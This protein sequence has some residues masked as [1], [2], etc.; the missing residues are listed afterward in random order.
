MVQLVRQKLSMFVPPCL[1]A[2]PLGALTDCDVFA[3]G[4]SPLEE[5]DV[6]YGCR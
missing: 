5:S 3:V 6:A 2:S 4:E 1:A